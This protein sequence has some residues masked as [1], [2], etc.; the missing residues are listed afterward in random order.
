MNE[1]PQYKKLY[2]SAEN[3]I[4]GGVCGGL[5]EYFETDPILVRV[6]FLFLTLIGAAGVLLYLILWIMIPEKHE[7][8]KKHLEF[9]HEVRQHMHRSHRAAHSMVGLFIILVGVLLLIDQLYPGLGFSKFW[10]VFI[11]AFGVVIMLK[12]SEHQD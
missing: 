10:P 4:I 9:A 2:R 1:R 7:D 11:I 3:R 12:K 6:I 8:Q 5:A